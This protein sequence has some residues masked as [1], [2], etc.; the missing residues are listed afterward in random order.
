VG[1]FVPDVAFLGELQ[2]TPLAKFGGGCW[3][4]QRRID[5]LFSNVESLQ[6]ETEYSSLCVEQMDD[7]EV[8]D[9]PAGQG[10]GRWY[11]INGGDGYIRA[12]HCEW[13]ED[14]GDA[15]SPSRFGP[16]MRTS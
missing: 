7:T 4:S 11:R 1:L 9:M 12:T 13:H 5:V 16:F 2:A 15:M 8:E 14:D 6:A 3:V 10:V